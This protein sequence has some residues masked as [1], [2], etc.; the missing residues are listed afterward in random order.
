MDAEISDRQ[1]I[2]GRSIHAYPRYLRMTR[3]AK[4][5]P[6]AG[7]AVAQRRSIFHIEA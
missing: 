6:R 1:V 4:Q 3:F 5:P 7:T 2:S